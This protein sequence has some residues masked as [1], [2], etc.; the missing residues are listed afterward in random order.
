MQLKDLLGK[1]IINKKNNQLTTCI[2][3]KQL[4][5]LNISEGELLNI[6]LDKFMDRHFK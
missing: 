1:I 4:K 6:E 5:K 3:R 2:K